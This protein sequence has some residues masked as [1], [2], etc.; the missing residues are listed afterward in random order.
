MIS[1]QN[2]LVCRSKAQWPAALPGTGV[3]YETQSPRAAG[4]PAAPCPDA[5]LQQQGQLDPC[6][7]GVHVLR[8]EMPTG[9]GT[10]QH[11][12]PHRLS[13]IVAIRVQAARGTMTL[14]LTCLAAAGP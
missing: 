3:Q 10:Q 14:E 6:L 11:N 12:I 8:V 7:Q 13:I 4:A 5:H 1:A 2:P 9:G